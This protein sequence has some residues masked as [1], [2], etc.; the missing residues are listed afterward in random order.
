MLKYLKL[1]EQIKSEQSIFHTCA[2]NNFES[3]PN[4]LGLI[5]ILYTE[6][7]PLG[8]IVGLSKNQ[9]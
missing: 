2:L 4:D 6:L 9:V 7:N 1:N 8:L 5:A 3:L